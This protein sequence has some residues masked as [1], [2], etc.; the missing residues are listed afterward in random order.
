[1]KPGGSVGQCVSFE[2]PQMLHGIFL[3]LYMHLFVVD[4][5]VHGEK[6]TK[7]NWHL[8]I[9]IVKRVHVLKQIIINH[10]SIVYCA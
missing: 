10:W 5:L 1:M 3:H 9:D 6:S 2:H 8:V 4:F 7:L